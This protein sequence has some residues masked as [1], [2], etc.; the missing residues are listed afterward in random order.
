M[1]KLSHVINL[2]FGLYGRKFDKE[3]SD[4]LIEAI[5]NHD[6]AK[7]VEHAIM[8]KFNGVKIEVWTSNKF[9]SYGHAYL[10]NDKM[11]ARDCQFR[12]SLKAMEKL[13]ALEL[14]L[15]KEADSKNRDDFIKSLNPNQ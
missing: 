7:V 12:P 2:T 4:Y 13:H 9:Y 10:L 15:R 14:K 8:F 6:E 11:V 1:N 3:W 5:E